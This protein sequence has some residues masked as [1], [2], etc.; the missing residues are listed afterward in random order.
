M[1]VPILP[2][3]IDSKVTSQMGVFIFTL[4]VFFAGIDMTFFSF[5]FCFY[6]IICIVHDGTSLLGFGLLF[7]HKHKLGAYAKKSTSEE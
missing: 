4:E 5:L 7:E 2:C 6:V 1:A 3:N